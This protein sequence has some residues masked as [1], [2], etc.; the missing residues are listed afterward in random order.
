MRKG[1]ALANIAEIGDV[2]NLKGDIVVANYCLLSDDEK[3]KVDT[4][5]KG[6]V[7]IVE[8]TDIPCCEKVLTP[9]APGWPR[10][11]DFCEVPEEYIIKV[12]LSINENINAKIV[13][14]NEECNVNEVKTG[15]NT[16]VIFVENNEYYYC[17]PV[18]ETKRDIKSIK[19]ITKPEGYPL[20]Y[21]KN[22][23]KIRVPGR[24]V[25]IAYVEYEI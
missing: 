25:D 18:V 9:D 14:E 17:L 20:K 15:E 4:Y 8:Y 23:F 12:V 13:F 2:D 1:A 19:I 6:R 22:H 10:P 5:D 7:I 16:S 21:D 3:K 24:G 11:L